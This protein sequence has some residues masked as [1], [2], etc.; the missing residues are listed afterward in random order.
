MKIQNSTKK[1]LPNGNFR[2]IIKAKLPKWQK[3][4]SCRFPRFIVYEG[5]S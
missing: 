1:N 5:N 3:S 4:F 2:T